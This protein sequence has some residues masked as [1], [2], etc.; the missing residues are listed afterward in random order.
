VSTVAKRH[1]DRAGP[2]IEI[3][4]QRAPSQGG[5]CIIEK[6]VSDLDE[7]AAAA[8]GSD[9]VFVARQCLSARDGP[10][11]DICLKFVGREETD[12]KDFHTRTLGSGL[13]RRYIPIAKQFAKHLDATTDF[14]IPV[15]SICSAWE[16]MQEKLD[17][18]G[19]RES[20]M[21]LIRRSMA[22]LVRD[23]I[24]ETNYPQVKRFMG[25]PPAD[26]T[27]IYA[28]AK[29]EQLG[30]ALATIEQIVDETEAKAPGA[31]R[32]VTAK[33]LAIRSV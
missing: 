14:C 28:L 3:G 8:V 15:N 16:T 17:L 32:K 24:G 25:H 12:G 19:D 4:I 1:D 2:A 33:S 13:R 21:K 5:A 27:D 23:R 26:V 9:Q 18:P 31:Y 22:S 30:I 11:V 6:R 7:Y 10:A 29:P 20:G